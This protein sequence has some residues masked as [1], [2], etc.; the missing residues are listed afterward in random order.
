MKKI[1]KITINPEKVIKNEDLVNLKGG[2]YGEG[3]TY[4][5]CLSSGG[6]TLGDLCLAPWG[7]A[8]TECSSSFPETFNVFCM[9]NSS[10]CGC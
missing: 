1:G 5:E 4:C 2:G 8:Y 3:C 10:E 9:T 6:G 7:D